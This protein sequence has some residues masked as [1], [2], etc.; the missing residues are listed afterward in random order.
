MFIFNVS[1]N[2]RN[3][4]K[5]FFIIVVILMLVMFGVV[6]YKIFSGANSNF[7]VSDKIKQD[8]VVKVTASN[9]TNVLKAVHDDID[10][11]VG[12][13][14]CITGY[15]YRLIDFTDNQFVLARDMIISSN[16][17]SV[18]V[19]FLCD[20]KNASDFADN[21]WVEIT[22]TITKGTYHGDIPVIK[23]TKIQKADVPNDEYVYPPDETY[24]PTNAML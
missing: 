3:L 1:L 2:K 20:Y 4:F 16:F 15:V 22:G 10:S 23:V 21:T 17:Q 14:V 13:N 9:Y 19:G 7:T 24:V 12:S 5:I 11:Y 6:A 8:D 18:V